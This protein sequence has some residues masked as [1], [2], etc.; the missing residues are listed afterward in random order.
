MSDDIIGDL[1][2][3]ERKKSPLSQSDLETIKELNVVPSSINPWSDSDICR[4]GASTWHPFALRTRNGNLMVRCYCTTCA[5]YGDAIPFTGIDPTTIPLLRSNA[6]SDCGGF[7]CD[8]CQMQPC[9][10]CGNYSNLHSHH[11]APQAIFKERSNQYPTVRLCQPCH[12]ELHSTYESYYRNK[13]QQDA[14]A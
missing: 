6:C 10:R 2:G 14:A 4:C 12:S 13:Y 1:V 11:I 8:E 9:Q 5:G 7:G 3:R